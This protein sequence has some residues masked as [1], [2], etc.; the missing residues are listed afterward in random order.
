MVSAGDKPTR[1][2]ASSNLGCLR[3]EQSGAITRHVAA[4]L[5]ALR[6]HRARR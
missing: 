3:C 1:A 2:A 4:F 6:G 5:T